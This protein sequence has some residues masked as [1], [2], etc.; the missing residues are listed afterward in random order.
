MTSVATTSGPSE[1]FQVIGTTNRITLPAPVALAQYDAGGNLTSWSDPTTT[2]T[3][4][5]DR[6]NRLTH[7]GNGSEGWSYVYTADDERL[8]AIKDVAGATWS[9]WTFR[10]LGNQVLVRDERRP[11]PT[12]RTLTQYAYRE[13]KL[14]ASKEIG[15]PFRDTGLDHLGSIRATADSAVG[16]LGVRHTYFP[17]GREATSTAQDDEVMKFT[18]HERD[19]QSTTTNTL[20]DLDYMHA[21]FRSPLTGRFLSTDPVSTPSDT[22]ELESVRLRNRQPAQS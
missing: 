1:T 13:G 17:F 22:A 12:P 18:G 3:Y 15:G 20:D 6:F 19:L 7:W 11:S 9:N 21:R 4:S 16:T 8:W 5:W 10:G 2:A 14:L